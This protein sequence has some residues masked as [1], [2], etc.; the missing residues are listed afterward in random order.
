MSCL[1]VLIALTAPRVLILLLWLF[2]RWFNGMFGSALVPVLGFL[3]LP[4]TLFWYSA[5][6]NWFGGNWAFPQI[7]GLIVAVLI[8][9]SPATAKWRET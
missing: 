1:L 4:T 6:Q 7:L 2:T 5:V 9:A 3:F 8:D